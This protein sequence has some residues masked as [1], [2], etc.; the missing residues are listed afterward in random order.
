LPSALL[1]DAHSADFSVTLNSFDALS[2]LW[3][4]MYSSAEASP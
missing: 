1:Y 4:S 2:A 3:I